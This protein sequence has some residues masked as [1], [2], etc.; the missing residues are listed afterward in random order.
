MAI[1]D[2]IIALK[3]SPDEL[4]TYMGEILDTV[5]SNYNNEWM[6]KLYNAPENQKDMYKDAVDTIVSFM[7]KAL[8]TG[9]YLNYVDYI[10][11][12]H[13]HIGELCE[14]FS[15]KYNTSNE[16]SG[17]ANIIMKRVLDNWDLVSLKIFGDKWN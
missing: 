11:L 12:P 2:K 4:T 7:E 5:K 3:D 8:E 13:C 9:Q 6:V 15:Q 10:V 1:S 16:L 17:C 14:L